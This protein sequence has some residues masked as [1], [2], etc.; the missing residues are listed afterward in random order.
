MST[1][2][3]LSL[4][5]YGIF[6]VKFLK[7]LF[8]IASVT[9]Q[10]LQASDIDLA[11][12]AVSIENL[13]HYIATLCSDDA[14]FDNLFDLAIRF[15]ADLGIDMQLAKRRKKARLYLLHCRIIFW[16]PF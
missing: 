4:L 11:T 6:G 14:Q 10:A 13:R 8:E 7:Q 16:T 5:L 12:A 15:C 3:A 1:A 2:N 9:S